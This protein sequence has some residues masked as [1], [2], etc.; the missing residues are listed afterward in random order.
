[1]RNMCEM[2]EK[3][4]KSGWEVRKAYTQSLENNAFSSKKAQKSRQTGI[5][6]KTISKNP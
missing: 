5:F 4:V 2:Y 1:M 6:W 3:C